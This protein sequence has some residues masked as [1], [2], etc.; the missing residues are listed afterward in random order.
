LA[1]PEIRH[2]LDVDPGDALIDLIAGVEVVWLLKL[3]V[4]ALVEFKV[5]VVELVCREEGN[6]DRE[7]ALPSFAPLGEG[8]HGLAFVEALGR[9]DPRC[10]LTLGSIGGRRDKHE[11]RE[12]KQ[13]QL[14]H[15]VALPFF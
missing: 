3:V 10:T 6:V 9:D 11:R 8:K 1:A 14:V 15:G 4:Q 13:K 5:I 7:I 12:R 2:V